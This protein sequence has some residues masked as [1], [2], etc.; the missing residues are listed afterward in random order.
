M[1]I[2][3][4]IT[5]IANGGYR[6]KPQLVKQIREPNKN[7]NEPGNVI[8]EIEPMV[9]NQ[10]DMSEEMLK[11]V[12][13]GFWLVTHGSKA[14]ARGYFKDEP[15]NAAGKT[16][17]SES[18]KNGVKTWN[19]SFAGYAPFKIPRLPLPLLYQMPTVMVMLRHTVQLISSAMGFSGIF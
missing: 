10:V 1:Q 6:M 9:L 15:Y 8:D 7:G 12:Q 18:Y 4:Y 17:A 13:H 3:Q 11:R 2:A 5:T 16:G 19:L 14:T